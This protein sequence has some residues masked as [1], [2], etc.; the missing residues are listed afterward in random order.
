VE[1]VAGELVGMPPSAPSLGARLLSRHR[2][3][4]APVCARCLRACSIYT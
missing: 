2:P 1:E 3:S 4:P